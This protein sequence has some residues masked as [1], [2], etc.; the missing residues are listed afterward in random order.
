MFEKI[1]SFSI[2]NTLIVFIMV[3]ALIIA[4]VWSLQ[5]IAID[6]VPDITNN[7]VQVVTTSPTLAPQEI[8]QVITFP[9]ESKLMN[10]PG[11]EEVRSISRFGLSVVTVVFEEHVPTLQARQLVKEQIDAA[12]ADIPSSLGSPELMPITTGLGE[13]Y[14][15]VLRVKPGYEHLYDDM[16]LRTIQDWIVKRQLAGTKG[17]IEISSFGGRVKQYEV[18]VD[19]KLLRQ[20]NVSISDVFDALEKNNEN[21]GGS[22]VE[23]NQYAY[24]IRSEGRVRTKEDIENI[25]IRKSGNVPLLIRDVAKVNL[26]SPNRYGA[27]TMDGKGEVVG[28]IT[29]MLKG[30]NSSDAIRNVHERVKKIASSLP[31]GIEIYPYMDRSVLVAKTSSTVTKNLIEGGLIVI[32]VLVVLLGNFRAGLIVASVIPLAMLFALIL[33]Y[34]FGVSANLMSLGAIDFGIVVD[35]AVII[36]ESVLHVLHENYAGK[37]LSKDEMG[38]VVNKSSHQIIQSAAFGVLIIL[39]V[40]VP[41]M[42]LTGIEGKMFKPM[43]QTVSF[44]LMGALILSLTYVPMMSS[45]F[46]KRHIHNHVS[47]SDRIVNFF[48]RIYTPVLSKALQFPKTILMLAFSGF[49]AAL[50]LFSFM[51]GEFIPTLEEGDLA[52]QMT[53]KPGSSLQESIRATNMA[54]KIL[55]ENFPEVKH[56]VAKIGTAEVPT[57]PMAMEDCDIMII[58]KEKDEWVSADNRE[59]LIAM[60]KEKLSVMQ[61]VSFEFSQPIQLRFNE[62]MTGAKTDIS[63]KIFGEDMS[64]LHDLAHR[65]AEVI[66]T[67][68]GAGDVKVEQTEG[69]QQWLLR[70]DYKKLARYHIDITRLNQ[71]IRASFAGEVS[72]FVYENERKFDL[73]VRM[74]SSDRVNFDLGGLFVPDDNGNQIPLNEL[75]DFIET[76]SPMLIS[77]EDARRR[78]NIGVNV[79]NRDVA[80]LVKEIEEK[81]HAQVKLPSGYSLKFGGQFENLEKAK[82][83]L[84]IAVPVALAMIFILLYFAF[85][86]FKY[87]TLIYSAV[88]LSAIGGVF[89]LW[90]RDM[91]F[92][93]SAGVGFIALFGV[94][95]LNG[96]VLISFFNQLKEEGEMD[97]KSLILFGGN[98]RMRPVIMTAA[99]ASLGFLP[100]AISNSNGAEVQ[101][102]LA[103]VVIGGLI[104]ATFL[105]L[106]V[107]PVLYYMV[108]RKT[109]LKKAQIGVLALLLLP[110]AS[111]AQ[112]DMLSID[113]VRNSVIQNHPQLKNAQ[114]GIKLEEASLAGV[115]KLNPVDIVLQHG[116]INYS[117][118]DYYLEANQNLGNFVSWFKLD[119]VTRQKILLA[120]SQEELLRRELLY[121]ASAAYTDWKFSYYEAQLFDSLETMYKGIHERMQKRVKSGESD[122]LEMTFFS[123]R[124]TTVK[125]EKAAA[126]SRLN[127]AWSQLCLSAWLKTENRSPELLQWIIAL[128][129]KGN[130]SPVLMNTMN[131]TAELSKKETFYA[132]S[133]YAPEYMVGYFNQSLEKVTGYWGFRAG[134]SIPLWAWSTKSSVNQA[135]IKEEIIMNEIE[136]R[137][138]ELSFQLEALFKRYDV[139]TGTLNGQGSD[140]IQN[141][142]GLK[143]KSLLQYVSGQSD[144]LSFAQIMDTYLNARIARMEMQREFEQVIHQIDFLTSSN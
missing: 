11:V 106:I 65:S 131:A 95:V 33:M 82:A 123:V 30:A 76:E 19:P 119:A 56:V 121:K 114:L 133:F 142:E 36:V 93:I 117:E 63:V 89:A 132:R 52:M 84:L 41:I 1:I 137:Q 105:T 69:L 108:E 111:N 72:G 18:S 49:T 39:I 55:L 88:P 3:L 116:Q 29:L 59:D 60:M 68:E 120:K 135:K 122:G 25:V 54:E 118:R 113:E 130:V 110:F 37:K 86:S 14:Q 66:S 78:I 15:Y 73:V 13:I 20:N 40:F 74:Q 91:P 138:Q 83:R 6:A 99:V 126:L 61:G 23:R 129:E 32:F 5:H 136:I 26:G 21:S 70:F 98:T 31:E 64:V 143:Q 24:Y 10:L 100:M 27:M 87:A 94:A 102:P 46:L 125:N 101:K 81:I 127:D 57:D 79:R 139:L 51:G 8:E 109:Y 104:T 71:V 62:L 144:F 96:I 44:A 107:L 92:S 134:I 77:R 34:A 48:K 75:V 16:E 47:I 140:Y 115:Y 7:Q 35:G 17:I 42:T 58:M 112:G 97:I 103:T 9:L 124:Y 43:A 90:L 53:L 38:D 50:I 128:K 141:L 12:A 85:G 4:G 28:G 45:L 2:R 22:Y 80:S 67:I